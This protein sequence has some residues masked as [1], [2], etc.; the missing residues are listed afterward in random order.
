MSKNSLVSSYTSAQNKINTLSGKYAFSPAM[1]NAY[2]SLLALRIYASDCKKNSDWKLYDK[3]YN[4]FVNSD[5][6]GLALYVEHE[7]LR[8][9]EAR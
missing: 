2:C 6:F 1:W 8:N 4:R 7:M 9:K 5:K 3:M